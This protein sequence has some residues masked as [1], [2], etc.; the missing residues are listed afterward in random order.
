MPLLDCSEVGRGR[1]PA[2]EVGLSGVPSPPCCA[3]TTKMR[4]KS[5]PSLAPV[6]P[7]SPTLGAVGEL[8]PPLLKCP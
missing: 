2:Q 7:D 5:H 1:G 8:L 6:L 4:E 3:V